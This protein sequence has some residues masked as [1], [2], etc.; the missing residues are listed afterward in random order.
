MSLRSS[1]HGTMEAVKN[2]HWRGQ[3]GF[4]APRTALSPEMYHYLTCGSSPEK[5][6]HDLT[7]LRACSVEKVEPRT[8]VKQQQQQ[9]QKQISGNHST[10]QLPEVATPVGA[11]K[12]LA[13]HLRRK[14]WGMRC[15]EELRKPTTHSKEPRRPRTCARLRPPR[16]AQRRF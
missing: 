4:G 5:A 16:E 15:H 6:C 14:L 13:G 10:S 3:V 11:N 7:F 1:S 12:S 8:S 2:G 9:Q